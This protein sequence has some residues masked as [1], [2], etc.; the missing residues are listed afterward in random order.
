[1]PISVIKDTFSEKCENYKTEEDN[2]V[3]ILPCTLGFISEVTVETMYGRGNAST[4]A[5]NKRFSVIKF[6]GKHSFS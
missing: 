6:S 4:F 1:M 2:H 3:L 5:N